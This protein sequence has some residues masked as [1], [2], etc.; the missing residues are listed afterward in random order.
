MP[1]VEGYPPE[2]DKADH[3]LALVPRLGTYRGLIFGTLNLDAPTLAEWLGPA[4][5]LIDEFVD[6]SPT[7]RAGGAQLPADDLSR[8]R[9]TGVGQRRRRA[10]PHLRPSQ[11]PGAQRAPARRR[12]L[13]VAV[14]GQ[15]P[16]TPACT[17][18]TW[19]TAICS[20]TSV[21]AS[22]SPSGRRS[23]RCLGREWYADRIAERFGDDAAGVLEMAPGSM[24]NLSIFPNLLIKGNTLET[25]DPDERGR[26]PAAHLG[27]WPRREHRRR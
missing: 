24:V 13:A 9:E 6:R 22:S 8:Q 7:G 2:F 25:V 23:G 18:S 1:F 20:W 17:A 14:Q 5:P 15:P 11:L 12:P 26:D 4:G 3:G 10:A 27:R 21:P 16:T 19:D